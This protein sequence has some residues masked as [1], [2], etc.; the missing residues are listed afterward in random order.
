MLYLIKL[1][2]QKVS[3]LEYDPLNNT[4]VQIHKNGEAWQ[5]FEEKTFWQW[6]KKKIDYDKET[7]SFAIVSD[8]PTFTIDPTLLLCKAHHATQKASIVKELLEEVEEHTT[9]SMIP[10]FD[11]TLPP[12]V[13]KKKISKKVMKES[14]TQYYINKTKSYREV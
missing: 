13:S 5:A 11:Y 4:F 12:K 3:L 9:L 1:I 7:L 8:V 10:H 6:F 2:N 14:L